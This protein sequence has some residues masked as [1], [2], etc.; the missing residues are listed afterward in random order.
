MS[1]CIVV[2]AEF[3]KAFLVVGAEN[4]RKWSKNG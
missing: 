1:N 2:T 3:V 4:V